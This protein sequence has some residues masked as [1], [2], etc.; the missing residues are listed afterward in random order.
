MRWGISRKN[1]TA[2]TNREVDLCEAV[3]G[4]STAEWRK[5]HLKCP[6]ACKKSSVFSYV[7]ERDDKRVLVRQIA[8]LHHNMLKLIKKR[9]EDYN[10]G[11]HFY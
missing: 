4:S 7:F 5:L 2:T 6:E 10:K 3:P 1:S 8:G 11:E 9:L